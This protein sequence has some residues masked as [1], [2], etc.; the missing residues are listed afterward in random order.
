MRDTVRIIFTKAPRIVGYVG[1][2]KE[3]HFFIPFLRLWLV[4]VR[5]NDMALLKLGVLL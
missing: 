3:T 5:S 4:L 2:C 1:I